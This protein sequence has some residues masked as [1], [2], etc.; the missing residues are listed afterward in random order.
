MSEPICSKWDA[1]Y[2]PKTGVWLER[3]CGSTDAE[4]CP[5]RCHKRPKKHSP[6]CE[7]LKKSEAPSGAG[8]EGT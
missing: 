1:R 2:N 7:C 8:G 4:P 3:W 5:Y 6:K